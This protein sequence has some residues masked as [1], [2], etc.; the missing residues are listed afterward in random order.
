V[1]RRLPGRDFHPLEE[2]SEPQV[3]IHL[4]HWRHDATWRDTTR[5][6]PPKFYDAS[7]KTPPDTRNLRWLTSCSSINASRRGG[8]PAR[9]SPRARAAQACRGSA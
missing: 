5:T 3:E 4:S 6:P 9:R 8:S 7:L 2:R 1:L